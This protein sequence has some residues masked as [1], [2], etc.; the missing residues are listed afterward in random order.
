MHS[1]ME[2]N[3][4]SL[5]KIIFVPSLKN[6]LATI[7]WR[8]FNCAHLG[9]PGVVRVLEQVPELPLC[10][11]AAA[12][13]EVVLH[14]LLVGSLGQQPPAGNGFSQGGQLEDNLRTT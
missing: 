12:V 9:C 6:Q 7:H 10:G 4:Y 5:I 3:I 14:L 11:G 1:C 8:T 2:I 13:P